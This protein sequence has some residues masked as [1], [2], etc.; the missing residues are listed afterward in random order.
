MT[1]E[2]TTSRREDRLPWA[3][4]AG[5]IATVTVFAV[6]QGLTYP[7]LSSSWS[8]RGRRPA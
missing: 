2:S 8:G 1:A 3:A 6:A 7:L 4:M 5:V